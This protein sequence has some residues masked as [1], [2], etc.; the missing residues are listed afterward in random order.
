MTNQT[1]QKTIIVTG[2]S[3]GIGKEIATTLCSQGYRIIGTATSEQGAESISQY[4]QPLD[5]MSKGICLQIADP[6]HI[7]KFVKQVS[8]EIQSIEALVNNAGITKDGLLM[9]MS[10]EAFSQVVDVN[11]KGTFML[12]RSIIKLMMKQRHGSIVNISSVVAST[13]NPGQANYVAS[14]AAL[15]GLTKV[16]ALEAAPRGIRV[17]S[18]APGFIATDMTE[19]LTEEQKKTILA[20]IPLGH[21]GK[22]SDIANAVSFLISEQAQYITGTLLHVNG[23]MFMN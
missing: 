10:E 23:G 1:P 4:L 22:P 21:M 7:D 12:M 2:A 5:A 9:R 14:K 20:R 16:A 15:E 19:S 17:N 18:V 3:R 13:G 11:L 6:L 8:Q